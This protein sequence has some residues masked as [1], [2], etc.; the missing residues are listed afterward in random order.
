MVGPGGRRAGG[1]GDSRV[2]RDL[3][4]GVRDMEHDAFKSDGGHFK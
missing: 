4:E 1:G 2:E 3:N